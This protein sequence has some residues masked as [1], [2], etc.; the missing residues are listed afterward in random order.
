MTTE[1]D[2]KRALQASV[3][4]NRPQVQLAEETIRLLRDGDRM[5]EQLKAE[6]QKERR[7]DA[8]R[9][10]NMLAAIVFG[11][12]GWWSNNIWNTVQVMQSQVTTL[13]IE[14][15]R[16]YVPRAELQAN[17][18]RIYSSLERIDKQTRGSRNEGR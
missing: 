14:L 5:N 7:V 3:D 15:A 10:I 18:D 6:D 12:M 13:N 2:A 9:I 8:Q 16:N 4:K 1:S 17:F 11:F